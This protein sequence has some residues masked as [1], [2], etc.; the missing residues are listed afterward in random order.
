MSVTFQG[1]VWCEGMQ[2]ELGFTVRDTI[3]AAL[4]LRQS[5]AVGAAANGLR[6][7]SSTVNLQGMLQI[8]PSCHAVLRCALLCCTMLCFV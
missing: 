2:D 3:Y 1:L 6:S 5:I 4:V 8:H 7:G